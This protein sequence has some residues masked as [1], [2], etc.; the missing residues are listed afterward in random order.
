MRSLLADVSLFPATSSNAAD[1]LVWGLERQS[2]SDLSPSCVPPV[3]C[4]ANGLA[5][6]SSEALDLIRVRLGGVLQKAGRDAWISERLGAGVR[7]PRQV[8]RMAEADSPV[9]A[10]WVLGAFERRLRRCGDARLRCAGSRSAQAP[11]KDGKALA[12]VL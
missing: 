12:K 9:F 4:G 3:A 8:T 5:S 7:H 11:S 6:R 1:D 10:P 2:P